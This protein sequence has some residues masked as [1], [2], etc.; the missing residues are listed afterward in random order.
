MVIPPHVRKNLYSEQSV[1][2][3]SGCMMLSFYK[4]TGAGSDF[5]MLDNRDHSY[6]FILTHDNIADICDRHFG[7]G[8]DGLIAVEPADVPGADARMRCYNS[9]GDENEMCND[10]ARCFTAFVDFLS[11]GGM[12]EVR[13]QT[14]AGIVKGVVNDD[15][16]VTI[17]LTTP[18]GMK[19][20]ALHADDTLTGPALIVFRGE[21][22]LYED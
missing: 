8:A 11:E 13:F 2:Y 16:S 22:L 18:H 21:V 10:G 20:N 5:V 9:D 1:C 6:S 4:M 12:K 14:L 17:Q 3:T 15:D 7:V 19:R